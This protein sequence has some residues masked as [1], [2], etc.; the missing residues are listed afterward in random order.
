M[1]AQHFA[2]KDDLVKEMLVGPFLTDTD[3]SNFGR[4]STEAAFT[5]ATHF[6]IV[7]KVAGDQLVRET[8]MERGTGSGVKAPISERA[9]L[10]A[11]TVEQVQN[12]VRHQCSGA[13]SDRH[14]AR[15]IRW[16]TQTTPRRRDHC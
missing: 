16:R 1:Q 6:L 11:R 9:R 5:L 15:R 12:K 14:C 10:T 7:T 8:L 2:S 4:G 3:Q 13:T